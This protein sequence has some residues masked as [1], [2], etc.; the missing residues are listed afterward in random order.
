MA[1]ERR[2]ATADEAMKWILATTSR[3]LADH[4]PD[5]PQGRE[6]WLAVLAIL[7][8]LHAQGIHAQW[9]RDIDGLQFSAFQPVAEIKRFWGYDGTDEEFEALLRDTDGVNLFT[10]ELDGVPT[11]CAEPFVPVERRD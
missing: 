9:A 10:L 6:M 1:T 7:P 3:T 8:E 4:Y 11:R 2:I 5:R